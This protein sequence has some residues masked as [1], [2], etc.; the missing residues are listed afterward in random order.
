MNKSLHKKNNIIMVGPLP[1]P[2]YGQ[3]LSFKR[4]VGA[5]KGDKQFKLTVINITSKFVQA[6]SGYSFVRSLEYIFILLKYIYCTLKNPFNGSVYITV[7]QSLSGFYRDFVM[8]WVA[9]FLKKKI[10]IHIKGGNYGNFFNDQNKINKVLIKVT[11]YRVDSVIVLSNYLINMFNFDKD[12]LKKV[13]VVNNALPHELGHCKL[14]ESNKLVNILFLSNLI[15]SKGYLDLVKAL[16]VVKKQ[17]GDFIASFAGEFM[18]SSDDKDKNKTPVDMKYEFENMIKELNLSNH[19]RYCGVLIG[20]DKK[21]IL[22]Q[23]DILV[24]PTNYINEG[25]PVSIIEAMAHNNAII[26]TKYRSMVDMIK[27]GEQGFFVEYSSYK[28]L[29]SKILK[30]ID[31]RVLLAKMQDSAYQTYTNHFTFSM[32]IEKMKKI[33][34]A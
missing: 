16:S 7:G 27:D 31:D 20:A 21:H 34:K 32:H 9:Y 13:V 10:I 1:P 15:V 33:L 5:M 12:L 23:S 24:L 14:R 3:S 30:L 11:L 2:F 29:A 19:V 18:N 4:L 25:Q 22:D 26:T 8:I 17:R 6:G 28:L